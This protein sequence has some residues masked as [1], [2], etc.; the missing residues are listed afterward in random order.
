MIENAM[1]PSCHAARRCVIHV[2][3]RHREQ[4]DAILSQLSQGSALIGDVAS[5]AAQR[6][7]YDI[8]DSLALCLAVGRTGSEPSVRAYYAAPQ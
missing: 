1:N 2:R 7:D 3:F 5:K 8:A 6:L 4:S